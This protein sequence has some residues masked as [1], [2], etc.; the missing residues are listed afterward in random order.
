MSQ[1]PAMYENDPAAQKLWK[2]AQRWIALNDPDLSAV[3]G[4]KARP[5]MYALEAAGALDRPEDAPL[6]MITWPPLEAQPLLNL[7]ESVER[8]PVQSLT[9]E[10]YEFLR[11]KIAKTE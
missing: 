5:I 8:K 9:T 4:D 1:I 3:T 11:R 6:P 7:A 2:M 10:Q